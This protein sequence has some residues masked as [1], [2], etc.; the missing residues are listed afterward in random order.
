[1]KRPVRAL[2]LLA[3]LGCFVSCGGHSVDL[4]QPQSNV[5]SAAAGDPGAVQYVALKD[6][7]GRFLVDEGQVFVESNNGA[8][9]GCV[10]EQCANT[11]VDYGPSDP[12]APV[13][14]SG[15]STADVYFGQWIG[16]QI[17]ADVRL[18]RCPRS[19]CKNGFEYVLQDETFDEWGL[20]VAVDATHVYWTSSFD[21]LRCLVQGCGEV[22]ELVAKGQAN[23][24]HIDLGTDRIYYG[25]FDDALQA[26]SAWSAPKDGSTEPTE[27][28]PG[29]DAISLGGGVRVNAMNA[30]W[31]DNEKIES[32]P[33]NGC[34][35]AAPKILVATDTPKYSLKVDG[36][37]LYWLEALGDDTV[38]RFCPVAGCPAGTEPS[39]L[40]P[41]SIRQYELDSVYVY[42]LTSTDRAKPDDHFNTLYRVA[43]PK[44]AP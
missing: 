24:S 20:S 10:F 38:L 22:P 36:A 30:Y 33:L 26:F 41:D 44:P 2:S 4:D 34:G 11:A 39:L 13:F 28:G 43:K 16:D 31:V 15:L 6:A 29:G 32:C 7:M 40:V 5:G 8:V 17:D 19:G 9:R 23:V 14:L 35:G 3:L 18:V 27:L 12:S 1:M 37:G 42:F 21:I 25:Q